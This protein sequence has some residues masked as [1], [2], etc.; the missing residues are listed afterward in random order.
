MIVLKI[1][2]IMFFSGLFYYFFESAFNGK[3]T[4]Q[5]IPLNMQ[6]NNNDGARDG[7]IL[8]YGWC[9]LLMAVVGS[10]IGIG[11]FGL[12]LIPVF[13]KWYMMFI[14]MPI[15]CVTITLIELGLGSLV[16]KLTKLRIWNYLGY[17]FNFKGHIELWHSVGWF[18]FG[19]PI[20]GLCWV[21]YN[22]VWL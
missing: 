7:L 6:D 3:F 19:I 1:L 2:F 16:Y 15:S 14:F 12:Y 18:A 9:S 22:L 11:M 17:K 21:L 20:W 5:A 10:L 4:P 8:W 13:Q